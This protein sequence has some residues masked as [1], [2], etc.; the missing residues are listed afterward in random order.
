[1][2]FIWTLNDCV[3]KLD[4]TIRALN[5]IS[6]FLQSAGRLKQDRATSNSIARALTWEMHPFKTMKL[7]LRK[8]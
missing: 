7:N 6:S 5:E 8:Q 1:M 2:W 4:V 3:R